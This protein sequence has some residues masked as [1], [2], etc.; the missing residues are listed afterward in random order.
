M[1]VD[2]PSI[3]PTARNYTAGDFPT[4]R[5]TSI[6]GAGTTRLYGSKAYDVSLNLE[7]VLDDADLTSVLACYEES[8]GSAYALSLPSAIFDGMS[9]ALQATIPDHVTW[10]W[11]GTPQ[12]ESLFTDRSRVRVNLVGTLDG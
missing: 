11:A 4:K 10:R 5:F 3:A 8:K 12:V 2:F 1:T 7:F 9:S 6:S